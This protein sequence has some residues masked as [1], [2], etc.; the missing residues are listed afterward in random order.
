MA[1]QK[2]KITKVI[3][4]KETSMELKDGTEISG[5]IITC[6]AEFNGKSYKMPITA[7]GKL[8]DRI[9]VGAEVNVT[10][11]EYKGEKQYNAKKD[12]N[13]HL[14]PDAKP[15]SGGKGSSGGMS[16]KDLLFIAAC[17]LTNGDPAGFP[18]ALDEAK[19]LRELYVGST[20]SGDES[21]SEENQEDVPF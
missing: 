1:T 16:E 6:Q 11:R 18:Q 15:W 17:C 5:K 12:E 10:S 3:S 20:P 8:S 4:S 21:A 13:M 19:A 9:V 2:V 14:L 7:F